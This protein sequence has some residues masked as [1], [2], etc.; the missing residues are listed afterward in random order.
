MADFFLD[1]SALA[2]RYVKETGTVWLTQLTDPGS[3]HEHWIA[4]ITVVELVA[5]L[6][7]RVRMGTMAPAAAALA[8]QTFQTEFPT[9]FHTVELTEALLGRALALV[10]AHFLRG[11][12]ALQLATCLE[13][14]E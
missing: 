11:F 12:D 9:R 3:G 13:I 5:A 1:T 14:H 7:R 6:Y 2:K 4:P 8:A 10:P